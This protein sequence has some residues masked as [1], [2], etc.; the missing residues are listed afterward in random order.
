M[1]KR[2]LYRIWMRM[3]RFKLWLL[4]ALLI[5]WPLSIGVSIYALR[6]NNLHMVKLRNAVYQADKDNGDVETALRNL[7][8]YV[9]SHMNTNLETSNGI[10]PPI[11]LQHTYERLTAARNAGSN[12]AVNNNEDLYN[13]AQKYCEQAIP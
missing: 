8:I 1:N 12:A 5:V 11:Q 7:R 3:R 6:Q 9:Y 10:Y 2:G 4:I 13:Q